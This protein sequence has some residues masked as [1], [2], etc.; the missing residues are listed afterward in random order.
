MEAAAE[1]TPT[2]DAG[3]RLMIRAV[4]DSYVY[5]VVD[6]GSGQVVTQV[7]RDEVAHMG[8]KADYAAGALIKAKA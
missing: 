1:E 4:G 7:S 3:Q 6:R 8:E 2:P 5:T